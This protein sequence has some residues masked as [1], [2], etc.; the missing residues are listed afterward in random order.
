MTESNS[1]GPSGE[2]PIS[3]APTSPPMGAIPGTSASPTVNYAPTQAGG[4]GGLFD[5]P[6][7]YLGPAPDKDSKTMALLAHLLGIFTSFVGALVIWLMKKDSS[8]FVEDQ[9]KE[10]LN[11]QLTLVIA[12][13]AVG[14][15]SG[16]LAHILF[17]FG[18]LLMPLIGIANLILCIMAA[19]QANQGVAYRY[20]FA[21]QII[22]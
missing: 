21:M 19:M 1:P 16:I 8:P 7:P 15:V 3:N 11:F 6:G 20:P 18:L 13:I 17:C 10:A 12:W 2:I 5:P 14:I 22:K 9:A 4:G